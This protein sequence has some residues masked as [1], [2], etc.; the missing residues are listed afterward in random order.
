M[1]IKILIKKDTVLTSIKIMGTLFLLTGMLIA[2]GSQRYSLSS[3]HAKNTLLKSVTLYYYDYFPFKKK[4]NQLKTT[5][6]SRYSAKLSE[7]NSDTLRCRQ[8]IQ[9][10]KSYNVVDRWKVQERKKGYV[11][12][13]V[14]ASGVAGIHAHIL[15]IESW[16]S[17]SHKTL[18]NNRANRVTGIFR[19]YVMDVKQYTFKNLQTGKITRVNATPNHPFYVLNKKK[20]ISVNQISPVDTLISDK[21]QKLHILCHKKHSCGVTLNKGYPVLVYNLEVRDNHTYFVSVEGILVHNCHVPFRMHQFTNE[22]RDLLPIGYKIAEK[23]LGTASAAGILAQVNSKHGID[24]TLF[25][26]LHGK[27]DPYAKYPLVINKRSLSVDDFIAECLNFDYSGYES[28]CIINCAPNKISKMDLAKAFFQELADRTNKSVVYNTKGKIW[29]T[30][31]YLGRPGDESVNKLR[32]V[33]RGR[34]SEFIGSRLVYTEEQAAA[35]SDSV[36]FT[37]IGPFDFFRIIYPQH[38]NNG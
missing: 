36:E 37:E 17:S 18:K 13:M 3:L 29:S 30:M 11:P 27:M 5:E 24:K 7:K 15:S 19:R 32:A 2:S 10:L 4:Y 8:Y 1:T 31:D 12:L 28:I 38:L 21:G 25:L 20:F 6:C 16:N 23:R 14:N 35:L 34:D 9:I 33:I 26:W 22:D